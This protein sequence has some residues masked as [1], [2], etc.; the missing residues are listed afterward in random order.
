MFWCNRVISERHQANVTELATSPT[1]WHSSRDLPSCTLLSWTNY[2]I[3]S[4]SALIIGT[5]RGRMRFEPQVPSHD[6]WIY[7]RLSPPYRLIAVVVDLAMM[8]TT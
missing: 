2:L 7:A 5:R 8:S 3:R 6:G 4:V 1:A